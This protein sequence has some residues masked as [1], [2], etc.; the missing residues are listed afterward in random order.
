[1]QTQK[2]EHLFNIHG[3]SNKCLF[4]FLTSTLLKK[5]KGQKLY[6]HFTLNS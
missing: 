1:M 5:K 2:S 3:Q 4:G 6:V